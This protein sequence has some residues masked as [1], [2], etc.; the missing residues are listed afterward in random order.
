VRYSLLLLLFAGCAAS[1][2]D[3]LTIPD[4]ARL[5]TEYAYELLGGSGPAPT[6]T[7]APAGDVCPECGGR[8]QVGDGTIDFTC[9]ECGG[10]GKKK[11]GACEPAEP[12]AEPAPLSINV[13]RLPGPKWTF[14][15]R[16][17][18]PPASVKVEHLRSDHGIDA[19]A[20]TS[21]EMS[22]IHD[23]SHNYG[24]AQAYG[25]ISGG[26]GGD[27]VDV[28]TTP[29]SGSGGRAAASCPTG[30]CPSSSSSRGTTVRRGLF[31]RWR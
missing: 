6:P 17:T 19:S 16:G 21:A 26:D 8:G 7:P 20:M 1:N 28:G 27:G 12:P 15:N 30:T 29:Q 3:V 2:A 23:N 22:A 14:E 5:G 9:P 31:G 24:E 11:S 4:R 13:M 10:T 25:N 18:N